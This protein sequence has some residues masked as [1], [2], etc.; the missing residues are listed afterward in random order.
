MTDQTASTFVN[1]KNDKDQNAG[2][3]EVLSKPQTKHPGVRIQKEAD[4][5]CILYKLASME[6]RPDPK[7]M[8]LDV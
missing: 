5:F 8:S 1:V 2:M 6:N 4:L 7:I 3:P